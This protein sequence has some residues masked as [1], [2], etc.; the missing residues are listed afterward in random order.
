MPLAMVFDV[1]SIDCLFTM[2]LGIYIVVQLAM[3]G[4]YKNYLFAVW[5]VIT[6]CFTYAIT[7]KSLQLYYN[8]CGIYKNGGST[9]LLVIC[10]YI[11]Q[12]PLTVYIEILA[13]YRL[14]TLTNYTASQLASYWLNV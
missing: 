1:L 7:W 8:L 10:F 3:Y 13:M 9:Q 6:S 4:L 5:L 14:H 11:I 2:L 12:N